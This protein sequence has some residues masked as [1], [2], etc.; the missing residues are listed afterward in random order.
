MTTKKKTEISVQMRWSNERKEIRARDIPEGK[1]SQAGG[2]KP[3]VLTKKRRVAL[4][5]VHTSIKW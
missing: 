1:G 5:G 4:G 3:S 2:L